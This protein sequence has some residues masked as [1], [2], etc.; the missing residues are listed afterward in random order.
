[1]KCLLFI[2]LFVPI[3]TKLSAQ[4]DKKASVYN[5][6]AAIKQE[7]I[8]S[9]KAKLKRATTISARLQILDSLS[10][11]YLYF[12][13]HTDSS[14]VYSNQSINLAFPLQ[15]KRYLILA[16][17]RRANYFWQKTNL[18]AALESSFQGIKLS[19]EAAIPDYLSTLY[20]NI[21]SIYGQYA[22]DEQTIKNAAYQQQYAKYSKDPFFD[23][24]LY[25]LLNTGYAYQIKKNYDSAFL[26]FEKTYYKSLSSKDQ[27][28]NDMALWYLGVIHGILKKH[29]LAD[30]IFIKGVEQCKKNYDNQTLNGIYVEQAQN[31]KNLKNFSRAIIAARLGFNNAQSIKDHFATLL[32]AK[33]LSDC[34]DSLGMR[35]STFYFLRLTNRMND[36]LFNATNVSAM[37]EVVFSDQIK[38][39]EQQANQVLE[40]EKDRNRLRLYGFVTAITVFLLVGMLMWRNS[41]QK[42]KAYALLQKQKDETDKQKSKVEIALIELRATQA[43]LIQSEK[44]AS[45]GELTAGIAHEIQNPLNFVNNFSE[46]NTE[47]IQEAKKEFNSGNSDEVLSILED[48]QDNEEKIAYHGKRAESIVKCML[49]HSRS[50]KGEKQ[51]TDINALADEYLRLAYHGFKAKDKRLNATIETSFDESIGKLNII[52]QDIGRVLLNLFNNA[53]YAVQEKMKTAKEGYEPK[54]E[55][56]SKRQNGNIEISVKDNGNGIPAQIVDKIF[57]P[58]FTTKPTG[59]GTGLGLSLSYDIVKAHGGEL[60]VKTDEGKGTAFIILLPLGES[61]KTN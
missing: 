24:S 16:Y 17:A 1:M 58:F 15:D 41:R 18:K 19:K 10:M 21:V 20:S 9:L 8:N 25:S 4:S 50:S 55:V 43:Q 29:A 61:I 51:V 36:S 59:Q 52:P 47:L 45:L 53:F 33:L 54:V 31:Q 23:Q 40:Q 27:I 39:K 14:L 12:S 42:E 26:N 11:Y 28:I 35:D 57:Q 3:L 30:S 7:T 2:L 56:S 46:T 60:K 5:N 49:E 32:S 48:I 13:I 34:Y 6:P 22:N 38:E 44:M 37:Q